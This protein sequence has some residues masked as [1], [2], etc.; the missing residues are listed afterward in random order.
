MKTILPPLEKQPRFSYRKIKEGDITASLKPEDIIKGEIE[1]TTQIHHKIICP[2][3]STGDFRISLDEPAMYSNIIKKTY[4][5]KNDKTGQMDT[6]TSLKTFMDV[7]G[8]YAI[9]DAEGNHTTDDIGDSYIEAFNT[10]GRC[11]TNS[12][13]KDPT[14]KR[15]VFAS[16]KYG[17]ELKSKLEESSS[18]F[19]ESFIQY[20][21]IDDESS[22]N[23]GEEDTSK[24][25]SGSFQLWIGKPKTYSVDHFMIPGTDLALYTKVFDH[26]K[27][28]SKQPINTWT[29]LSKFIYEKGESQKTG[30]RPFR[31]KATSVTLAPSVYS[32]SEKKKGRLQCKLS[33]IHIYSMDYQKARNTMSDDQVNE[34]KALFMKASTRFVTN[35]VNEEE[36][37]NINTQNQSQQ[38]HQHDQGLKRKNNDGDEQNNFKKLKFTNTSDYGDNDI[39]DNLIN[40]DDN[41]Y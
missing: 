33:E 29:H 34:Q 17:P 22:P 28:I 16:L 25:P 27:G 26:T 14:T 20:P 18:K 9:T 8:D 41:Q 2:Q 21:T 24:T 39:L 15:L 36:N 10:I 5:K 30:R 40:S 11:Y 4:Q 12:M 32:N 1:G 7:Y 13:D 35:D 3:S 31:F 23:N 19:M 37:E 38:Q 6:I